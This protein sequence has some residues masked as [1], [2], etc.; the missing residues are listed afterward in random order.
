MDQLVILFKKLFWVFLALLIW[1]MSRV[2]RATG[3]WS[4]A[5]VAANQSTIQMSLHKHNLY[6]S[7]RAFSDTLHTWIFYHIGCIF[8][9]RNLH[10]VLHYEGFF[11]QPAN[12]VWLHDNHKVFLQTVLVCKPWKFVGLISLTLIPEWL[13]CKCLFKWAF[14][15]KSLSQ[16]SH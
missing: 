5:Y 4:E 15:V 9:E 14:L 2:V 8:K 12:I 10:Y 7:F 13:T 16:W 6:A 11:T 3:V 1:R